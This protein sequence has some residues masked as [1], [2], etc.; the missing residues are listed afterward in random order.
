MP[1]KITA[2]EN[3]HFLIIKTL[4]E[5]GFDVY[6]ITE[7]ASGVSDKTVIEIAGNENSIILTEDSDFGEWVFAH[8]ERING[9]IYLRYKSSEL[10]AIITALVKTLKEH[11]V[12]LFN[13]FT[14]ITP[15]KIRIRNIN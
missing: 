8:K 15:K 4:R 7:K 9:V 12:S 3:I 5:S 1:L 14:V 6:S 2:D 13:K 10:P 11:D